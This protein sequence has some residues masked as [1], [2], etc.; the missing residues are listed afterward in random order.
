MDTDFKNPKEHKP[1]AKYAIALI[2]I[3]TIAVA[4]TVLAVGLVYGLKKKTAEV[5]TSA[6]FL[7]YAQTFC[8]GSCIPINE[9]AWSITINGTMVL[10][11]NS[12]GALSFEVSDVVNN[13]AQHWIF[14]LRQDIVGQN[15]GIYNIVNAEFSN[16]ALCLNGVG[17]LT[18]CDLNA[19]LVEQQWIVSSMSSG[20]PNPSLLL[21]FVNRGNDLAFCVDTTAYAIFF[22]TPSGLNVNQRFVCTLLQI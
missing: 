18:V 22:D 8:P 3:A 15:R 17:N 10:T 12:G 20:P 4:A 14:V 7:P 5:K 19:G 11:T 16:F 2:S 6:D 9:S 21:A 13:I 1:L